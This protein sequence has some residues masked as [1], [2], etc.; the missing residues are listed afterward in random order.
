MCVAS[1]GP[2]SVRGSPAAQPN[3]Q[4][5]VIHTAVGVSCTVTGGARQVQ[6]SSGTVL[7]TSERVGAG[8]LCVCVWE[9]HCFLPASLSPCSANTASR[10]AD[11]SLLPTRPDR[12]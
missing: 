4:H 5:S 9:V 11:S 12:R 6:I 2:D 1:P 3:K 10:F 8:T 7:L